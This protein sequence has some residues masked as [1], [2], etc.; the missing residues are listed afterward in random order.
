M[1]AEVV[2]SNVRNWRAPWQG[3]A[4]QW[5][6]VPPRQPLQPE[7]TGAAVEV[8]KWLKPSG[9]VSRIGDSASV[10]A[11]TRVNAEQACIRP[12]KSSTISRHSSLSSFQFLC[13]TWNPV[14][15]P[16]PMGVGSRR[17]QG[18][19]RPAVALRWPHAPSFP[20]RALIDP[21]TRHDAGNEPARQ[22]HF[23]HRDQGAVLFQGGT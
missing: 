13:S 15:S 19:S 2:G 6:Q 3:G 12:S 17:A 7:A 4:F 14:S 1:C 5:V 20:G 11:V 22:T 8:T 18:L 10:Q 16:R 21:S 23:D 9:S